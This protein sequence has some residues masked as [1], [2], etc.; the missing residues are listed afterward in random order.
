MFASPEQTRA[1]SQATDRLRFFDS[2]FKAGSAP[3]SISY[4]VNAD[5]ERD[6]MRSIRNGKLSADFVVATIHAHQGDQVI[7]GVHTISDWIIEFAHNAIDTGADIFVVHGPH[8]LQGVEIYKGKPI[9]YGLSSFV[10][11]DDLQISHSDKATLTPPGEDP[12]GLTQGGGGGG[13]PNSLAAAGI[14]ATSH[15][16]GG[17][18]AEVRLYPADLGITRRPMSLMG[19]PMTPSPDNARR[20]LE[21]MQTLSKQFGTK[22][23]IEGGVGVIRAAP[24]AVEL[25]KK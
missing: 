19:L 5:D 2:Y 17:R 24:D 7:G 15:Y 8:V 23:D 3:G 6:I 12:I 25:G 10:F 11:Q 16:E 13:N 22:I 4:E 18:L 9:F 20:I 14:L 21:S 1:L